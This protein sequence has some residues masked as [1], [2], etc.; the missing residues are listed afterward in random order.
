MLSNEH[1]PAGGKLPGPGLPGLVTLLHPLTADS[2]FTIESEAPCP[3]G[4]LLSPI[5]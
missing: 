4:H 5:C 1:F 2:V 3:P